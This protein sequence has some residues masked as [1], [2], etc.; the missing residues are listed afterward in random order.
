MLGMFHFQSAKQER[1]HSVHQGRCV[2]HMYVLAVQEELEV[3]P[4]S[5]ERQRFWVS[6]SVQSVAL[7]VRSGWAGIIPRLFE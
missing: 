5:P 1:L 6:L 4:E 7:A 3:W 2:A